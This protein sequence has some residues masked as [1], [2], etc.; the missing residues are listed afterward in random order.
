MKIYSELLAD[1][2]LVRE[3]A[4]RQRVRALRMAMDGHSL[5]VDAIVGECDRTLREAQEIIDRLTIKPHE[6]PLR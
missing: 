4:Q 3:E 5:D 1:W 2:Q 6:N